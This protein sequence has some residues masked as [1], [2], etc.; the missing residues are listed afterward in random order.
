MKWKYSRNDLGIDE[1]VTL[2][3]KDMNLDFYSSKKTLGERSE[4]FQENWQLQNFD[5]LFKKI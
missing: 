5:F 3:R 4:I 2:K 1:E